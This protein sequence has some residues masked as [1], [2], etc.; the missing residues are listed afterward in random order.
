MVN[1]I[2]RPTLARIG[3]RAKHL[4]IFLGMSLAQLSKKTALSRIENGISATTPEKYEKIA[5]ALRVTVGDL[6]QSRSR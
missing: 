1:G 3:T 6:F 2:S 4:R 5:R